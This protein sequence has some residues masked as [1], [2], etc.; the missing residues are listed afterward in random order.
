MIL[1][2]GRPLT[3]GWVA[4]H[5]PAILEAWLPGTEGGNAIADILFGDVNPGAKLPVTFPRVV[6]Q[7]PL[8]YNH[9]NT[10]RPA[11]VGNRYTSKYL[12]V[13]TGPL[14]AFGHGLSYTSFQ[15]S[16][17]KLNRRDIPPD[18]QLAVSV[19]V[20]NTGDHPGDEVVQLY[21]RDLVAS[22]LRSRERAR[23]L[24]TCPTSTR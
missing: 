21:I 24:R 7:V 13:P 9:L 14:F 2:N 18:G 19:D 3:I 12:D 17:L 15:L 5:V 6:G 11:Q 22:V 1:Y 20:K 23:R 10:G 16:S 8:H 4:D